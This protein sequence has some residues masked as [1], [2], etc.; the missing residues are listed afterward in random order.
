MQ[1]VVY[2]KNGVKVTA[3]EVDHATA[4][5]AL[6]YRVDYGG[7]SVMVSGDTPVSENLIRSRKGPT[8]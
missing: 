5:P 7:R 4:K 2:E 3:F 8:F 6:G 1:G